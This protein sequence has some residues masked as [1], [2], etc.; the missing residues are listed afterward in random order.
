M[1]LLLDVCSYLCVLKENKNKI[2]TCSVVHNK[3][4]LA[5]VANYE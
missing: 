1:V 5:N 3:W 4:M 2:K